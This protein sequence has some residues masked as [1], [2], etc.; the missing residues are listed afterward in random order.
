[1]LQE[2]ITAGQ[3]DAIERVIKKLRVDW[4]YIFKK[5]WHKHRFCFNAEIEEWIVK[6]QTKAAK[7]KPTST[8]E[9]GALETLQ[10]ELKDGIQVIALR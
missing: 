2:E 1:M 7:I 6:A 9:A 3:G 8:K 4:S 5:K 10:Q